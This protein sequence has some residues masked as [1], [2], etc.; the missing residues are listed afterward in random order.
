MSVRV[1]LP[2]YT[3]SAARAG[4]HPVVLSMAL[5]LAC[6]GAR[7]QTQDEIVVTARKQEESLQ[8]VPISVA[9][10]TSEQ[11]Q[12]LGIR[13]NYDVAAFTPN[14]NTV[15][16]IGRAGDRPVIR[17]MNNPPDPNQGESNASYFID[18]VFVSGTIATATTN[19]MER[20][21]ILRGPQSAQFGRATFSGAVNYITRTPTNDFAGDLNVRY[22]S[23]DERQIA[24]WFSGPVIEDQLSFLV[25]ASYDEYGG[26]WRNK[27]EP[28]SAFVN[29]AA[30]TF[31][32]DGQNTEGDRSKLGKE[33]TK[34]IL[35]KLSW[36]PGDDTQV[37]FKYSYTESDDS[38]YPNNLLPNTVPD[39]PN[40]NCY[41]PDDPSEPWFETSR[42]EFCGSFE[43]DNTSN[44][45]NIP[46]IKKGLFANSPF[47]DLTDEE[48]TASPSDPGLR[49]DTDRVLAEWIQDLGDW[50]T[51][52]RG[53]YSEDDFE[54]VIDLDAQEVR[55]VWGLF[56]F[57]F[58]DKIEDK[59]F[60]FTVSSPDQARLRGKLGA[61]YYDRE[62]S[63][64]SRSF[65]G[66]APVFGVEPGGEYDVPREDET[67]SSSVFGSLSFDLTQ[68]LTLD[69]EAR[70]TED[71][72]DIKSGQRL[73]SDNSVQR[74]SDS[75]SYDN[76]TPRFTLSWKATDD[77]LIYGLLAKGTKPGGFN[78]D[79]FRSNIPAE[80]T[81]F[82]LD[83][84]VGDIFIEPGLAPVE[85]TEQLKKDI[86]FNEEEQWTYEAG[87]KSAWL[88][89]SL[90]T[91]L[92]VFYIDWDNQSLTELATVPNTA[93]ALSTVQVQ[94][95]AGK[96]EITGL[97][98]E[99]NWSV[100]DNLLVFFNYGLADGEFRRG[101]SPDFAATTGTDGDIKGNQ[102]PDSPKHS[103]VTGFEATGQA[104]SSLE[105]FLRTD[106]FYE[107]KR[108]SRASNLNWVDSRKLVNFRTGLRADDW[109]MTFYVRNLMNDDTPVSD[110]IFANY[111]A[112]PIFTAPGAPNDSTAA[113]IYPKLYSIIP[114]RERDYGLEFQYRFGN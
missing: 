30:L 15:Q 98:L 7:S 19:A 96:S 94:R 112:N 36:T 57:D 37:N 113:D 18:G 102:L 24:G 40:L 55:A 77:A 67:E 86:S 25:S 17:G 62:V 27:L 11:M 89:G 2:L 22:G 42:G 109:T 91:N 4:L 70:Y 1:M 10:F 45:K 14:F 12:D 65:T 6:G 72:Q 95:N 87:V 108:Y 104:T 80:F 43:I 41:V 3:M 84:D 29:G 101:E 49:R 111:A 54:N 33:E 58:D 76:F 61:Y 56:A 105:A 51:T 97:E 73:S 47:G 79:L 26:Q 48:R 23:S 5:L 110:F 71:D 103:V 39:F 99:T 16:R 90:T 64:R 92:S 44:R 50:R 9:A 63:T 66:P 34:D 88:D 85:C 100:T 13:N 75:R 78:K 82:Q 69:V 83:C 35:T 20:V 28:D 52:L 32:F 60:E 46:D 93:G 68:T 106:Y 8:D 74:I 114:Q 38:L 107:S 21:E 53:S 81:E 59:S 31:V